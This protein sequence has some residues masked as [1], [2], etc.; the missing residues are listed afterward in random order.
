VPCLKAGDR[1]LFAPEAVELVLAE[2]AAQV[3]GTAR[4][5]RRADDP[6]GHI[7]PSRSLNCLAA[8]IG[9]RDVAIDRL[10]KKWRDF[11][12]NTFKG[13][14]SSKS[15]WLNVAANELENACHAAA[16]DGLGKES[17]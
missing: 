17:E 11:D 16:N 7:R 14:Q 13:D 9:R 6:E 4:P 1:Y 12:P 5:R 15:Y 3:P 2:R 8:G 10:I